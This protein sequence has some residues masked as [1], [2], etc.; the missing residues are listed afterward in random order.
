MLIVPVWLHPRL[1][2]AKG[3]VPDQCR[4]VLASSGLSQ[5][6]QFP[7]NFVDFGEPRKLRKLQSEVE[8]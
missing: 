7:V 6:P 5:H 1:G 4:A 2:V 3:T 8:L